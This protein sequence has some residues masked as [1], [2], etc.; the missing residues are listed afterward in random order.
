MKNRVDQFHFILK[1]CRAASSDAGRPFEFETRL[2]VF[3]QTTMN[4]VQDLIER[5][6]FGFVTR[7]NFFL[8]P[9][10]S[11][12]GNL[13]LGHIRLPLYTETPRGARGGGFVW[14][15]RSYADVS[16]GLAKRL[17]IETHWDLLPYGFSNLG[18]VVR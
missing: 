9:V 2:A 5:R 4:L 11:G 12:S 1:F 3:D 14:T 16:Q 10:K 15:R 18:R 17:D 6:M 8:V 7:G 13:P